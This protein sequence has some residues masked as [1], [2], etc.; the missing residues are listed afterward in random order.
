M[1][2]SRLFFIIQIAA[3]MA[4]LIVAA[5]MALIG[6]LTPDPAGGAKFVFESALFFGVLPVVAVGAPIYFA[7]LRYGKP[8]WFYVILLGIAPG[9]AALP[10]DVLLGIFAILCGAAIASLTHLMC[11]GLGPNNSFKPKPLRGSA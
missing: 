6:S 3:L 7:L 4:L 9:V 10:F 8:R 2:T 11:R 5:G 1:R